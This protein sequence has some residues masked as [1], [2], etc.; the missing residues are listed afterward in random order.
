MTGRTAVIELDFPTQPTICMYYYYI[1]GLG[2]LI[3]DCCVNTLFTE[4]ELK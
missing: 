4:L 1:L 3:Y 2:M